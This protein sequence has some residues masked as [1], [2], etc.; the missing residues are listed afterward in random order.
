AD[1]IAALNQKEAIGEV[2][3]QMDAWR[4][5]EGAAAASSG[6]L[7]LVTPTSGGSA[8]GAGNANAGDASGSSAEAQALKDRVKDLEGQLAESKRLIDIRNNELSA[9]QRKLGVPA[10]PPPAAVTPTRVP[11]PAAVK[12]VPTPTPA[13]V[14]PPAAAVSTP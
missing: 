7:R 6:R 11:P 8:T 12:T 4:T 2:R 5:G 3:R 9:L 10:T 13:P 14:A 1:E